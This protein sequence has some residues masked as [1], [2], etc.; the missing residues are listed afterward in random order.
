MASYDIDDHSNWRIIGFSV[1]LLVSD[2][3]NLL[4]ESVPEDKTIQL[5]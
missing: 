1:S 4:F 3:I 2:L 5:S